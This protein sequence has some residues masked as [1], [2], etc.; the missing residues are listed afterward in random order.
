[1]RIPFRTVLAAV[2]VA[3][4]ATAAPSLAGPDLPPIP[5]Y[6]CVRF[7]CW[8]VDQVQPLV[9]DLGQGEVVVQDRGAYNCVTEPCPEPPP[10]QV[11]VTRIA[12]CTQ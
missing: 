7:P 3:G 4:L 11:C 2:A 9:N 10:W 5:P 8:P 1:M 6:E 12:F